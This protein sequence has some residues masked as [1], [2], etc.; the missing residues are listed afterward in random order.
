MN[1]FDSL[2]ESELDSIQETAQAGVIGYL[3]PRLP[4]ESVASDSG[5]QIEP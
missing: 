5:E 2:P 1:M 3:L 4:L